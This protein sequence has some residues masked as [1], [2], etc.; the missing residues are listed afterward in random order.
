MVNLCSTKGVQLRL[1]AC[2]STLAVLFSQEVHGQLPEFA[3]PAAP[4]PP[5][6][7]AKPEAIP[8][9]PFGD[10]G[11]LREN[12]LKYGFKIGGIYT[13]EVFGNLSGGFRRGAIAEGLLELDLDVDLEKF[14]GLQGGT[15]HISSFEIH[16]PSLTRSYTHDLSV[17]SNIDAFDTARIAEYWYQQNLLKDKVSLKIGQFLADNEFYYSDYGNLFICGSFGAFTFFEDNFPFVSTY[18]MSAPGIRLLL[19]PTSALDLRAAVFSGSTLSEKEN[20][21]SAPN[22]RAK[23][24]VL[25]LYEISYKTNHEDNSTGLPGSYKIGAIYHTRYS[26]ELNGNLNA[27]NRAAY[28][29]YLTIDQAVWQKTSSNQESKG[30]SL[31][32]FTRLG[33]IPEDFGF[34][35]HYVEGGLNL[36]GLIPDRNDDIFGIGVTHSGISHRASAASAHVG[37]PSYGS[38]TVIEVTYSAKINAWLRL[39]PDFQYIV[40]PGATSELQNAIV[41]GL[42]LNATF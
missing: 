41:L 40:N 7:F 42:R 5:P 14:I 29:I 2:F 20:N 12:L 38:E 8:P 16:G 36:N 11:G 35:S 26:G 22:I 17:V 34:V 15:F 4:P 9:S 33:L 1:F 18:P 13:G 28:G 37:G 30:P 23:D 21:I 24:G 10:L 3:N 25:S 32:F 6:S 27:Q 31:G 19:E 39:Q